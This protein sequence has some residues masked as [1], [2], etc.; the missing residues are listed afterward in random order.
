MSSQN[1][2]YRKTAGE[3][4][5]FRVGFYD[6]DGNWH[7]EESFPTAAEAAER[8]AYL[9][10]SPVFPAAVRGTIAEANELFLSAADAVI[11]LHRTIETMKGCKNCANS[12]RAGFAPDCHECFKVQNKLNGWKPNEYIRPY[13]DVIDNLS[14]IE[15]AEEAG[16]KRGAT[17]KQKEKEETEE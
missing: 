6:P 4:P 13:Y 16:K 7:K 10:G 5:E 1:Y 14:L 2:V 3:T 12:W 11:A 17:K 15:I 9:N 8:V